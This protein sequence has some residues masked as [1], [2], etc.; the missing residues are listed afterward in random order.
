VDRG[1]ADS[2]CPM[3]DSC[4]TSR[5][6]S[7]YG[8]A[9]RFH[10][11]R[12]TSFQDGSSNRAAPDTRETLA[13]TRERVR[14]GSCSRAQDRYFA[15]VAASTRDQARPPRAQRQVPSAKPGLQQYE[16]GSRFPPNP[17]FD[18]VE[19]PP[20]RDVPPVPFP[21]LTNGKC[22]EALSVRLVSWS[23]GQSHCRN[24]DAPSR[25]NFTKG[26]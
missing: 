26:Q 24:A 5:G 7:Q 21:R 4:A 14:D 13:D 11:A 25:G 2:C 18:R 9:T 12:H 10:I 19:L 3:P 22:R 15:R 8:R 20:R 6:T 23:P 17:E 1:S 16:R